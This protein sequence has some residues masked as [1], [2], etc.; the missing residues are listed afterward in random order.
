MEFVTKVKELKHL[1]TPG[2][3]IDAFREKNFF[4]SD[5]TT[6]EVS[7]RNLA[8]CFKQ[9]RATKRVFF[10]NYEPEDDYEYIYSLYTSDKK[11]YYR[12]KNNRC[13]EQL[14]ALSQPAMFGD[15]ASQSTRVDPIV[16]KGFD[17]SAKTK[18]VRIDESFTEKML[19]IF[20]EKTG[21]YHVDLK[22]YKING[23]EPGDFF[24]EHRDSPNEDL[25]ATLIFLIEGETNKM[26][27]DGSVWPNY[28]N[29][30]IFFTDVPHE[31]LP[32][33][34]YRETILFKVFATKR[35]A[36]KTY[37]NSLFTELS[38]MLPSETHGVLLQNGYALSD[39]D[40]FKQLKGVDRVMYDY[41]TENKK[42]V[43]LHP[44][45]VVSTVSASDGNYN[46]KPD[47]YCI[48]STDR[49]D[50]YRVDDESS[51]MISV[52]NL[53]ST[54]RKVP[55]MNVFILGKGFKMGEKH[56]NNEYIGNEYGGKIEQNIYINVLMVCE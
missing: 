6:N 36:M 17:I 7:L 48:S 16:R 33:E 30:A 32:V 13:V 15:V 38:R 31:V 47:Y 25:L 18:G 39:Y 22:P 53:S 10:G 24:A 23:Y 20:R 11:S 21:I 52:H 26:T 5:G 54:P 51:L 42:K 8:P 14:K 2:V 12:T 34:R 3:E 49:K 41:Y 45:L 29:I 1:L 55:H 46:D 19:T 50:E 9:S 27:I 28:C 40:N 37:D 44:V 4:E 35:F 56:L 43:S